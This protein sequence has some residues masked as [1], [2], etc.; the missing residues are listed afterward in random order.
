MAKE[1]H[2]APN[3]DGANP[4]MLT[5][6]TFPSIGEEEEG[7]AVPEEDP[8]QAQMQK[9]QEQFEQSQ[10][11]F[12]EERARWQQT[13]DRLIQTQATPQRQEPEP[14][15]TQAVDFGDLPDPVDKPEDFKRALAEKFEK[16]LTDRMSSSL[17]QYQQ[18]ST[19]QQTQQQA[20]DAMWAKFQ[21]DY[22]DLADKTTTLKGAI[23]S[24]REALQAR[25]VDPQQSILSDPDGFM[26]RVAAN[27]RAELG[28]TENPAPTQQEQAPASTPGQQQANRTGGVGGG[29]NMNGTGAGKTKQ[30]PKFSEQL[31]KMQLDSGLI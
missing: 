1:N 27:M 5:D 31:K 2:D 20:F 30:P 23:L 28:I 25:G 14:P 13:V 4:E 26:K 6:I 24:E 16:Q 19:Q 18:Q 3:E 7:E 12:N 21:K 29:T 17:N 8:V 9:L 15:Q 10:Q 22:A 11:A